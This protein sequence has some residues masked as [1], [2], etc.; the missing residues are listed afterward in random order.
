MYVNRNIIEYSLIAASAR[1]HKVGEFHKI[2]V[3]EYFIK[4]LIFLMMKISLRQFLNCCHIEG[5]EYKWLF[6]RI[7]LNRFVN[8]NNPD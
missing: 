4:V 3:Q 5:K 7:L 8:G 2:K 1:K 6:L